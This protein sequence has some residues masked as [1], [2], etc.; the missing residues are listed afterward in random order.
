MAKQLKLFASISKKLTSRKKSGNDAEQQACKH[1][2]SHGLKLIEKNFS[3][4][5]GE[6]DLIMQDN[7][8]LVFV[9]VR[10]RKNADFGGAAAS[11]TPKK[12]Q[13]IIKAALAYQQKYAPQSS[14]RF[15]VVAIEGDNRE[16]DWIQN[17]FS[18][19]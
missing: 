8:A 9:E 18:G 13:R 11:V 19:F 3:T 14:M 1:L 7:E 5:A 2:Q 6:V 4:K 16:L 15:D 17:A 12:Q 10:Y